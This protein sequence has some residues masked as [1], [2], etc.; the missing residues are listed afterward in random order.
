M[1]R[2]FNNTAPLRRPGRRQAQ[3]RLCD[4]P[5]AVACRHLRLHRSAAQ[6]RRRGEPRA[7]PVLGL[8][9]PDLFM[10]RVEADGHWTLFCPDEAPRARATCAA[11]RSTHSTPVRA[12]GPR[13]QGG[14]GPELWQ[15]I[16]TP[17][18]ETGAP[19]MIYKDACNRKSNQQHLGTIQSSNLCTEI[20]EYRR[21][22]R[23]RCATSPASRCPS[24]STDGEFD[25]KMLYEVVKRRHGESRPR[26]RHQLLPCAEARVEHAH[27]PLSGSASR[28]PPT[29]SSCCRLPFD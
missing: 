18:I 22:T 21:R 1:L 12:R 4:L 7:R 10:R 11:R 9:V 27:R 5:R 15:A 6:H 13:R 19:Y 17:Q 26:H 23:W 16:L 14:R 28:G 2:V 29:P 8:W 20:V 3:G 25:H 24:S